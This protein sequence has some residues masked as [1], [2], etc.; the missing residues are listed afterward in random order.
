MFLYLSTHVLSYEQTENFIEP[1]INSKTLLKSLS[2]VFKNIVHGKIDNFHTYI[3]GY[4]R[5]Y[6]I[7]V[8]ALRKH[9]GHFILVEG[10]M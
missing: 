6:T 4:F 1:C 5:F 7:H 8:Y 3:N 10:Y 9:T 2:Y